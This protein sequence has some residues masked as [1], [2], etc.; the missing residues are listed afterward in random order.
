M[1]QSNSQILVPS[2]YNVISGLSGLGEY[3]LLE[4]LS[5]MIFFSDI[6]QFLGVCKKTSQLK[7]H[8]RFYKVFGTLNF[9]IQIN[10]PNHSNIISL[11]QILE[12]GIWQIEVE[13][14]RCKDIGAIGIVKEAYKIPENVH[15]D[16]YP[17]PDY[18]VSYAMNG[19]TYG[20]RSVY[21][22]GNGALGNIKFKDNQKIKVEYDSEKGTLIFFVEGVQQPVYVT[23]I[24]EKVL[25]IIYL[26]CG[27]SSCLI[28]S[29]KK[30]SS[31]TSGHAKNE[32]SIQW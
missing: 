24:N 29:L 16:V 8:A 21:Y 31:P 2:K 5:E 13:F 19:N 12:N 11:S 4:I 27:G 15:K 22:N 17:H 26:C 20:T 7:K 32:K 25:F 9:P 30:L 14:N 18:M 10:N 6:I 3:V 1:G 28:R 23:G